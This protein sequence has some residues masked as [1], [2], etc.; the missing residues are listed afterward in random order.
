MPGTLWTIW[1][2]S[3]WPMNPAPI[4]PTRIGLPCSSLAFRAVSTM[5]MI[6]SHSHPALHLGPDLLQGLPGRV[7]GRDDRDRQ[8]PLQTQARIERGEPSLGPRRVELADLVARL[9]PVLQRLVPVGE[10]LGHVQ[11]PVIVGVQL[12]GDALQE[13]R[14]LRPQVHDDVEDRTARGADE[15][16]LGMRR[17]LEMHSTQRAL[18]LVVGD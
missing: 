9:G 15:L 13:S 1:L 5:I 17:V 8:R 10:S 14:T 3:P 7:L 11:R 2:V 6:A 18:A 12:H 16:G 4:M